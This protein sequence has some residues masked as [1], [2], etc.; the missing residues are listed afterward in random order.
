MN[1]KVLFVVF[2]C[3]FS[4]SVICNAAMVMLNVPEE[5]SCEAARGVVH[6]GYLINNGTEPTAG[7]PIGGGSWP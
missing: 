7:D 1:L 2:L 3:L 5:W 6:A 4:A